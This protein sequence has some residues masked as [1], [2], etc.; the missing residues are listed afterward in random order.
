M[1]SMLVLMFQCLDNMEE[2]R[3]Y[4]KYW[5]VTVQDERYIG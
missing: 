1:P 4:V 3:E 2:N 5:I